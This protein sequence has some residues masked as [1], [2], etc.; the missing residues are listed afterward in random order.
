MKRRVTNRSRRGQPVA[1]AIVKISLIVP[2]FNEEKLIANSLQQI[3]AATAAFTE[4]GWASELIVCDNNSTDR[5]AELAQAAGAAVVFEPVNQISRAR[6]AGAA[7]RRHDFADADYS[8]A[9]SCLRKWRRTFRA[10]CLAGGVTVVLDLPRL[11]VRSNSWWNLISRVAS[12]RVGS[13]IF[14][15]TA[16]FRVGGFSGAVRGRNRVRSASQTVGVPTGQAHRDSAPASAHHVGAQGAPLLARR[17]LWFL[18]QSVSR[19]QPGP[20]RLRA[21]V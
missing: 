2:A 15:E 6:N 17:N 9:P 13:F 16:A 11:T 1:E 18:L 10:A 7:R 3:R 19:G 14:C 21:V 12:G 8:R 4:R 5:T 20:R